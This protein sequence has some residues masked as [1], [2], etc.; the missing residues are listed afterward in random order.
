MYG[1]LKP[2][3]NKMDREQRSFFK[4][5]YCGL[6]SSLGRL[7]GPI[8]RMGLS[9]DITYMYLLLDC[10][11]KSEIQ[12]CFCPG[13]IIKKRTC[14]DS[15]PLSDYMA[16]VCVAMIRAKCADNIS[17]NEKQLESR[18]VL[19]L[20][21]KEFL[22][23]SEGYG[24]VVDAIQSGLNKIAYLEKNFQNCSHSD[25]AD[26]FGALVSELFEKAP[27]ISEPEVFSRLGYW[28]GRWVY[29]ADAA[30]DL[31]EDIKKN[32]FNPFKFEECAKASY[33]KFGD[34]IFD[35]LF[36]AHDCVIDILRLIDTYEQPKKIIDTVSFAMM[37]TEG[38][39]YKLSGGIRDV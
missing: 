27:G 12:K 24:D 20:T 14:I 4:M 36:K 13:R 1:T 30:L 38:H 5:Y 10:G 17:D 7:G 18:A 9:Y 16:A 29:I 23:I 26:A 2:V 25:I 11:S 28:L 31:T 15:R 8:M 21:D 37:A 33:D 34:E 35:Q 3:Y 6:C 22:K 39:V 32:R 19:K